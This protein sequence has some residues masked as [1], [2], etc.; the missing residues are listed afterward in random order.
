MSKVV[1]IRRNEVVAARNATHSLDKIIE[2]VLRQEYGKN[3]VRT[4]LA[5]QEDMR[6]DYEQKRGGR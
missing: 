2:H 6:S 5:L 3:Y 4:L 1:E